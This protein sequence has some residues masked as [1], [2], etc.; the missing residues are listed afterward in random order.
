MYRMLHQAGA[1][2]ASSVLT[3]VSISMLQSTLPCSET[4]GHCYS[5]RGSARCMQLSFSTLCCSHQTAT[6]RSFATLLSAELSNQVLPSN[7]FCCYLQADQCK[8]QHIANILWAFGTL[9]YKPSSH[10]LDTLQ[11]QATLKLS[12]FNPQNLANLIWAFARC[13][14]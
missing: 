9:G 5:L 14:H 3:S 8:P 6:C 1:L 11:K 2:P 12:G 4:A 10:L 7:A 13:A